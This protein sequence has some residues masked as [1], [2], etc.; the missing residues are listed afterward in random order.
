MN[1]KTD[2]TAAHQAADV[3]DNIADG[4]KSAAHTVGGSVRNAA[5]TVSDAAGRAAAVAEDAYEEAG[6]FARD[7]F[8]H[9]RARIRSWDNRFES[10]VR[11]NPRTSLLLAAA[12]GTVLGALIWKRK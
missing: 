12:L 7:S 8:N 3:V 10:Y 11:C 9:S 5:H 4:I 6:Q 1:Q 2:Q